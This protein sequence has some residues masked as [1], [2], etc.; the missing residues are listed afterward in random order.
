MMV[1]KEN[2]NVTGTMISR[3][4]PIP[5]LLVNAPIKVTYNS[6]YYAELTQGYMDCVLA[7]GLSI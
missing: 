2:T 6:I 7:S 5:V 3:V 1:R 4:P